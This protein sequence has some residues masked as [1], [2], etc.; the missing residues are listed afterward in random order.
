MCSIQA[1]SIYKAFCIDKYSFAVYSTID[2]RLYYILRLIFLLRCKRKKNNRE[3]KQTH[4]SEWQKW[5]KRRKE[6]RNKNW[7]WRQDNRHHLHNVHVKSLYAFKLLAFLVFYFL[8]IVIYTLFDS[9]QQWNGGKTKRERNKYT[10]FY[11]STNITSGYFFLSIYLLP[12]Q[13]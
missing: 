2:Y 9:T 10:T 8:L 4:K 5:E 11:V 6:N 12:V 3:N 7:Y 1:S 13:R